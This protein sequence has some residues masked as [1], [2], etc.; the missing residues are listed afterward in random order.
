MQTKRSL[1]LCLALVLSLAACQPAS[2]SSTPTPAPVLATDSAGGSKPTAAQQSTQAPDSPGPTGMPPQSSA[3]GIRP[4][5]KRPELT[6]LSNLLHFQVQGL[7]KSNWGAISD[8]IV[9]TCETYIVYFV[10]AP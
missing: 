7:D 4:P 2:Q 8:Y 5:E 10:L 6:R 1:S 3:A 9:N